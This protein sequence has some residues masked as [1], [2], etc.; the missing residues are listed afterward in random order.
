MK[1]EEKMGTADVLKQTQLFQNIAESK[2]EKVALLTEE[3]S[4]PEGSIL[5]SE[6]NTADVLYVIQ[7]GVLDLTFN[8]KVGE[9]EHKITIDAKM[10]FDCVGWSALIPPHRYTLFGICREPLTTLVLDGQSLLQI[11][12]EDPE[13]GFY[14]MQ[15]IATLI[16]NRM[17]QLQS[18]FIQEVRR[19][20][21]LP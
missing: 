17:Q 21:S 16:S 3:K 9:V 20:I 13:F 7:E 2:L 5:F 6:G 8:F 14:F 15:N 19:G 12:K 1:T 10:S 18:M 4:F 11:I